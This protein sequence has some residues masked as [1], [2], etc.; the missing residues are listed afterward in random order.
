V[1]LAQNL[2]A[3]RALAGEG[4]QKGHMRL[5]AHNLALQAGVPPERAADVVQRMLAE[6]GEPSARRAAALWESMRG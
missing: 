5:H 1:G 4:I 2:S 6:G 3:L